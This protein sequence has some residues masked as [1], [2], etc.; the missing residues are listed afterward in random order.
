MLLPNCIETVT[1]G[2]FDRKEFSKL[3]IAPK[4]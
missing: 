4:I 3:A 1:E 2:M